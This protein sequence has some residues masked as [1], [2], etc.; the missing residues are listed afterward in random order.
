MYISSRFLSLILTL[1]F[2]NFA[3]GYDQQ[4]NIHISMPVSMPP[5]ID[6]DQISASHIRMHGE[7][8]DLNGIDINFAGENFTIGTTL[9]SGEIEIDSLNQDFNGTLIHAS[10]NQVKNLSSRH[11]LFWGPS[12]SFGHFSFENTTLYNIMLGL[13]GGARLILQAGNFVASPW[14]MGNL[15]GGYGEGYVGG[16]FYDNRDPE[17]IP[18]FSELSS[19]LEI[20]Y[21]P[22]NLILSGIYQRTFESGDNEQIDTAIIQFG[23]RYEF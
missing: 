4:T 21:F 19:G 14:V 20:L 2:L 7:R 5:F 22:L 9:L 12:F 6:P 10:I 11:M 16:E 18:I 13:Q 8:I 3:Y 15:M 1:V 17:G 23:F